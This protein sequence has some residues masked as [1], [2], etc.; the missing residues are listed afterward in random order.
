[1]AKEWSTNTGQPLVAAS[2]PATTG[3]RQS[4]KRG[5]VL[6]RRKASACVVALPRLT[7]ALTCKVGHTDRNHDAEKRPGNA[8]HGAWHR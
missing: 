2:V 8:W 3:V 4:A 6:A 7:K 5:V 1:M